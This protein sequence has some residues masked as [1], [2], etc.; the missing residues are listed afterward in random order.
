LPLTAAIVVKDSILVNHFISAGASL[1]N[2]PETRGTT[3]T[4][5]S[6]AVANRDLGLVNLLIQRGSNPYD[7]IALVEATCDLRLLQTLLLELHNF[8][9]PNEHTLG[10]KA[11]HKAVEEQ[12]LVMAQAILGSP[13]RYMKSI[14]GL[15]DGLFHAVSWDSTPNFEII[16]TFLSQIADLNHS[17]EGNFESDNYLSTI[18]D[19]LYTAVA[20]EDLRK[21][22]LLLEACGCLSKRVIKCIDLSVIQRIAIGKNLDI[23][24]KLLEYGLDPSTTSLARHRPLL[25]DAMEAR[26]VEI[27]E[28]LLEYGANPNTR[29]DELSATPLQIASRNGSKQ[30]V[31]LLLE[32]GADV[33][34]PPAKFHGATAL[35]FAAMKGLL[36]IAFLLIENGADVN[37]P[38]AEVEGRTALEGAAEYGRLDMVQLLINAGAN[39]S[40][41]GRTQ[42]EN[43]LRR[44]S[45][46]GHSAVRR[47]L[48][49]YHG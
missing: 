7:S 17:S 41:E 42:Y 14:Q 32:H 36:G 47:L 35:Q 21:V 12:N 20:K 45:E 28:L 11:L 46:N 40:Q 15:K 37:A 49:S 4:P 13:I 3:P 43:A 34:A 44:A 48:E 1:N 31:E 26:N 29:F 2:P 22:T 8:K 39:T 25:K 18:A 23:L 27:I 9:E 24:R 30:V 10:R 6:A 16:R 19:A 33:N 38:P 5:L